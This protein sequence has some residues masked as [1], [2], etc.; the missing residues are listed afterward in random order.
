MYLHFNYITGNTTN[1]KLMFVI[2]VANNDFGIEE[3]VEKDFFESHPEFFIY[4]LK[5]NFSNSHM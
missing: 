1:E 2:C 5:S 3:I 4:I